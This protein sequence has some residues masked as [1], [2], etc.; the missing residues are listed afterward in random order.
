MPKINPISQFFDRA[1]KKALQKQHTTNLDPA[2]R[3]L[4]QACREGLYSP[5][6]AGPQFHQFINALIATTDH[7]EAQLPVE[8]HMFAKRNTYHATLLRIGAANCV[9]AGIGR[10]NIKVP[11]TC[12]EPTNQLNLVVVKDSVATTRVVEAESIET[13]QRVEAGS[14]RQRDLESIKTEED[15]DH[16][17]RSHQ[18]GRSQQQPPLKKSKSTHDESHQSLQENKVF[19]STSHQQAHVIPRLEDVERSHD[20]CSDHSETSKCQRQSSNG[21]SVKMESD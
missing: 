5:L 8:W 9:V 12:A 13:Q 6:Y 17:M 18:D 14:K 2:T 4:A 11:D 1:C 19:E 3:V 21:P 15:N 10:L 20:S 16:D 7:D